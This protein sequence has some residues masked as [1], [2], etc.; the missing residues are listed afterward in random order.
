M[1][2]SWETISVLI[3]RCRKSWLNFDVNVNELLD[4]YNA[5]R[6]LLKVLFVI[7]GSQSNVL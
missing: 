5:G 7:V 4:Q 1:F 6:K 3:F 2:Q